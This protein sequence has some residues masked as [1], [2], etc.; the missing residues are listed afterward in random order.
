MSDLTKAEL[1]LIE[2]SDTDLTEAGVVIPE[3]NTDASIEAPVIKEEPATE[4]KPTVVKFRKDNYVRCRGGVC[5]SGIVG[6]VVSVKGKE[7]VINDYF[8]GS[9]N[10]TIPRDEVEEK[11]SAKEFHEYVASVTSNSTVVEAPKVEE[12]K[13]AKKV[14]PKKD[15][16]PS[17]KSLAIEI[18]NEMNANGPAKRK[19]VIDRFISEVGLSK[20]GSSTYYQNIKSGKW[21]E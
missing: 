4:T 19:D 10:F 6:K 16:G 13:E 9:M 1:E 21:V 8:N 5:S 12:K 20:P 2:K 3:E 17:K 11:V 18:Y 15:K 7:V 14:E